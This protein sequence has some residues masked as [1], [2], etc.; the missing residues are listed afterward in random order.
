MTSS[1]SARVSPTA[2]PPIA[3]PSKGCSREERRG[4]PPQRRDDAALHDR[5]ERL[6]RGW[7]ARRGCA[8]PSGACAPSRRAWSPRRSVDVD[9]HVEHHHDVRADGRLHLDGSLGRQ[10]VHLLVD[11]A[12]EARALLRDG[13][14]AGQRE[15]LVAAR[16]GQHGPRPA[17]ELVDAAELAKRLRARAQ[18]QVIGVAEHHLRADLGEVRRGAVR[19]R[20]ARADVHE[21][22]RLHA[23]VCGGHRAAPRARARIRRGDR[24]GKCH[25]EDRA[26]STPC[27]G[28]IAAWPAASR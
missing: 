18:H 22:R 16:V 24:E 27:S 19:D 25:E 3:K 4:L 10:H 26:D 11:V 23:S 9:A 20:G 28:A 13:A 12:L 8:A 2:R 1:R 14:V 7:C 15:D 6:R 21:H 17:H 5:E